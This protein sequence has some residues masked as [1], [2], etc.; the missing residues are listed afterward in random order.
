MADDLHS[1]PVGHQ[2][3][4]LEHSDQPSEPAN[5]LLQWVPDLLTVSRFAIAAIWIGLANVSP[6]AYPAFAMLAVAAA[7]TDFIDGRIARR[8]GVTHEAG[9]WLDSIADVIFVLAALGCYASQHQLPWSIPLLIAASF[10]Q[11]AFDSLWFHRAGT[12][13][14]SRLGHWGGI[15]NYALVIAMAWTAAGSVARS[16]L[17]YLVPIIELFYVAAI[18]ERSLAYRQ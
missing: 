15:I 10:A 7:A 14:R 16:Y 13:V 8:L 12:P 4:I 11:Y 2:E 18:I 6:G 5:G 1:S 17:D 9:G 3:S